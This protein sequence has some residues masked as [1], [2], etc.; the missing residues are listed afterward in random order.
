[1]KAITKILIFS[2]ALS[3]TLADITISAA[4]SSPNS[5]VIADST[6]SGKSIAITANHHVTS[7]SQVN[8][9]KNLMYC[10]PDPQEDTVQTGDT[11]VGFVHAYN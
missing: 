11:R 1:M 2:L 6:E 8:Q 3:S 4:S 7:H 10:I 5:I 9:F